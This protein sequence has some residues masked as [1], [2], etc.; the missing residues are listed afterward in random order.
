ME[1]A[2]GLLPGLESHMVTNT[3]HPRSSSQAIARPSLQPQPATL[4]RVPSSHSVTA[5]DQLQGPP[6][7]P[8]RP[9]RYEDIFPGGAISQ[10]SNSP[11]T[12]SVLRSAPGYPHLAPPPPRYSTIPDSHV[13]SATSSASNTLPP[14]HD[15]S[16]SKY[17]SPPSEAESAYS[18][19]LDGV[20]VEN[21]Y[22]EIHPVSQ[23]SYFLLLI[24]LININIVIKTFVKI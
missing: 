13:S 12:H 23:K 18:P 15:S 24:R 4:P 16:D 6:P 11:N 8:E 21:V 1:D 20:D 5:N 10:S 22:E 7:V 17:Y 9:P 19:P 3:A 14:K 2:R